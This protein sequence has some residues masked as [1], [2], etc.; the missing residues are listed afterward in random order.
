MRIRKICT[1]SIIVT[2]LAVGILLYF[3]MQDNSKEVFDGTLV[4]ANH[5]LNQY[6]S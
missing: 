1:I 6:L 2:I 3:N 5:F 4:K